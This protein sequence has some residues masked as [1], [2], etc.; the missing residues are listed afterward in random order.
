M[1]VAI[2][3]AGLAGLACAYELEKYGIYPVIYE[4]NSY[5]G[6]QHPHVTAIL[7]IVSREQGDAIKFI[8]K[9]LGLEI[10]PLNEVKRI[11]HY[12]PNKKQEVKGSFGYFFTRNKTPQDV[13]NQIYSKLTKTQVLFSEYG[14][15]ETLA[16]EYD[17]V[18]ISNGSN[19]YTEELGCWQEWV[20][21]YLKGAIVQGNFE[22]DTLRVWINQ[23]YCKKGYAYLTPFDEKTA[24]LALVVTD[25]DEQEVEYY[26]DLFMDTENIKYTIVEEFKLNH[27]SGFVYPHKVGNILFAGNSAGVIDPFLGF[28]QL[29]AIT[30]GVLA[31]RAVATGKDYEK[32]LKNIVKASKQLHEF[33][34]AFD[35][36]GHLAYDII[37]TSVGLPVV[38]RILYK[39]PINVVRLGATIIRHLPRKKGKNR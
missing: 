35:K 20:N 36:A 24:T 32:M 13:K 17:Y 19:N 25:I 22:T 33:R 30:T 4:K 10:E 39:S 2:I 26:W 5:I 21:T 16:K 9:K 15:Y 27:K 31:G 18:I 1:K 37:M 3:G 12:S 7:E 8:K 28:G 23:D 14:D 29:N 34:K 6:E 11:L 38:R